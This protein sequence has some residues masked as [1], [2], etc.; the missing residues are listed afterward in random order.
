MRVV[1]RAIEEGVSADLG[2]LEPVWRVAQQ[3]FHQAYLRFG[4]QKYQAYLKF[5]DQRY[6]AYLRF[7]DQR[8]SSPFIKLT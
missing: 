2:L 7:G 3:P 6:Q 8:H 1:G 4:D 5:E